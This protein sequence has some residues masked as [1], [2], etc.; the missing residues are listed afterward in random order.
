MDPRQSRQSFIDLRHPLYPR[1]NLNHATHE[2]TLPMQPT[3]FSR[4]VFEQGSAMQRINYRQSSGLLIISEIL[5][6]FICRQFSNKFKNIF[7]KFECGFGEDLSVQHYLLLMIDECKKVIDNEKVFVA[8][9]KYFSIIWL[10]LSRFT[11]CKVNSL[12]LR[13]HTYLTKAA[14]F[15]RCI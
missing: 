8:P 1:Q 7:S 5:E 11:Y 13:V 10:H 9:L 4:F 6:K 2:P 15:L 3:L 12:T 14:N